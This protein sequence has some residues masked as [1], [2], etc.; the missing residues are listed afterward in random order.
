[1]TPSK[2]EFCA[3]DQCGNSFVA[4][5]ISS[6]FSFSPFHFW[7]C[8]LMLFPLCLP[9]FPVSLLPLYI[10]FYL[11]IF[12]ITSLFHSSAIFFFLIGVTFL[13]FLVLFGGWV[14]VGVIL[15][16]RFVFFLS[17][18][19]FY[20]VKKGHYKNNYYNYYFVKERRL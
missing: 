6:S 1:M 14:S 16:H 13:F 8:H 7:L 18:S 2:E 9:T 3:C 19:T 11:F 10:T 4:L 15:I 12:S 17:L 5:F 20:F